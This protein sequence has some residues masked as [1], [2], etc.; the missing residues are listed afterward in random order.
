MKN[1]I[2][3]LIA[4]FALFACQDE[5]E[6]EKPGVPGKATLKISVNIPEYRIA[7]RAAS[8]ENNLSDVWLLTFD[9]NG[10]FIGRVHATDLDSQET[11][12]VGNGSFKAEVSEETRIVH[13][14]AN[15]DNWSSFDDK[16]FAEKD[17]K[18]LMPALYGSKMVF[19][20]RSEVSSLA[21]PLSVTLFRNQAK[22]TVQNETDNFTVTGY[23]LANIVST[24]TV[25]PFIPNMEPNP[26]AIQDDITTLPLGTLSRTD[27]SDT[28]CNLED[29]YMFENPNYYENQSF[30]I[31]KG[32]LKDGSELYYKIQFLDNNKRPY[33]IVR[34][35][36]YKV[37]IK[38]FSEE[39]KGSNSFEDAKKA[40]VSNNIYADIFKDSP[41]ISDSD[42]NRLTVSNLNFL[43]TQGGTLNVTAHYTEN[44]VPNDK[45]IS[46][47]IQ[48]DRGNIISGLSYD[49]NGNITARI[50][51]VYAGQ[52]EATISVKAGKLSRTITVT[53]STLYSFS[54]A[55]FTPELYTGK[56]QDIT[57]SFR[58]PDGIPNYLYPLKCEI[59]TQYLY[60][61]DPN[62][63][64]Q[65]NFTNG[66][67]KYVYWAESPGTKTLNFKTSLDNSNE[68]V[69]I[70]NDY[71]KTAEIN[72]VSR[73]FENVSVNN[74]N[75]IVYGKG[76]TATLRFTIPGY[77]DY[78]PEYPLTVFV[79]T[80]KLT[81]S[82]AGWTAVSGGYSYTYNQAPTGE[83]TVA[84]TSTQDDSGEQVTVSAPGFSNAT[85]NVENLVNKNTSTSGEIRVIINGRTY[86]IPNYTVSSSD[87]SI[88][89]SFRANNASNY[90]ISVKSGCKLSDTV[91]LTTSSY[92]G[93][94]TVRELLSGQRLNLQ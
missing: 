15:Y 64:L 2:I 12:G 20:G 34:N 91:S 83:Q 19:W 40:E 79:A 62:K 7:T 51:R 94:F 50:A 30:L 18:E 56:D 36:Q 84:F 9:M 86:T 45:E 53:S 11:N 52:N 70:E 13:V 59:T 4:S 37:I 93:T 8:F 17:E 54:P 74:N 41:S 26:F 72:L 39:A 24:G 92:T 23:A 85:I 21:S 55:A 66:V 3:Y 35:F 61:T 78:P 31:I 49:G 14:V 65:I 25:A 75:M 68:T 44:E 33:T 82:Q 32:R 6:V 88:L 47:S 48:E 57:L 46:V 16:A 28:D 77:A 27:Q 81:T 80:T 60:P 69:T 1:V 67:Y 73:Q 5:Y 10:L 38:S 58:I 76:N 63:D 43:Y 87:R 22:V 29:K 71:F 42:N 90:N 89:D